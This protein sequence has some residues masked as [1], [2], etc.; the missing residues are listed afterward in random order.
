MAVCKTG[1]KWTDMNRQLRPH[2]SVWVREINVEIATH[3]HQRVV[4]QT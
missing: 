2:E 4:G 3:R 1:V